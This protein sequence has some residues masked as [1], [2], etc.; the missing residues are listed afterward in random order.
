M[1]WDER[2]CISSVKDKH[3]THSVTQKNILQHLGLFVTSKCQESWKEESSSLCLRQ[4]EEAPSRTVNAFGN[5]HQQGKVISLW[6]SSASGLEDTKL[7]HTITNTPA[8]CTKWDYWRQRDWAPAFGGHPIQWPGHFPSPPC[9]INRTAAGLPPFIYIDTQFSWTS[10]LFLHQKPKEI[11]CR[12]EQFAL[13]RSQITASSVCAMGTRRLYFLGRG[14]R[15]RRWSFIAEGI[16]ETSASTWHR[17]VAFC[18]DRSQC[19]DMTCITTANRFP[20]GKEAASILSE[21]LTLLSCTL[22]LNQSNWVSA[23]QKSMRSLSSPVSNTHT[24]T[25]LPKIA[26]QGFLYY[27]LWTSIF[28]VSIQFLQNA[29]LYLSLISMFGRLWKPTESGLHTC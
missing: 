15:V 9:T 26:L 11:P 21:G 25:N 13:V 16:L 28:N 6:L 23:Q 1:G 4:P 7:S 19:V 22:M 3:I 27:P 24:L 12:Q 5:K 20:E 18:V 29:L 2:Y 17:V 8:T 10:L 14:D